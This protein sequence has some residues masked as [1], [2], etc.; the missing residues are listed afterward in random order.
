MPTPQQRSPT[1]IWRFGAPL[2]LGSA[3]LLA[4]LH[5]WE[6]DPNPEKAR[7]VYA[8]KLA[9][10]LPTACGGITKYTSP[11]PVIVG[12]IWSEAQCDETLKIVLSKG[13]ITIADCLKVRVSQNTFDALSSHGHNNGNM[14]TCASRAVGLINNGQ[15]QEGCRA[16]AQTPS[17][18][19]NW[20]F[21]T[22]KDGSKRFVQG[23]Y[24]RR[25]AEWK[26]CVKPDGKVVSLQIIERFTPWLHQS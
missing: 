26:L 6:D 21:V 9:G 19:P 20:S 18:Q 1:V 7:T 5:V 24:N 2:V 16:L 13:Q 10:N 25:M 23:L 4:F 15:L 8:D 22:Q 17:G 3:G 11:Y 12:D 14:N